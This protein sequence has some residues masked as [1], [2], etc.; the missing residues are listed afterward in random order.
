MKRYR[1]LFE[2]VERELKVT[3]EEEVAF[4]WKYDI[5]RVDY[6]A[7]GRSK[8]HTIN[9]MAKKVTSL[10]GCPREVHNF[11]C[12]YNQL[13]TLIGAPELCT[14]YF[15]CDRNRLKD[16]VGGPVEVRDSYSCEDNQLESLKGVALKIGGRFYCGGNPN[17]K[18]FYGL[19]EVGSI[20]RGSDI[21]NNLSPIDPREL[22]LYKNHRDVFDKWL[23]SD[24]EF[25]AYIQT[26]E[27]QEAIIDHSL[28]KDIENLWE[29]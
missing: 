22:D 12:D 16:L 29:N 13:E 17:L 5:G 24:L 15:S 11:G 23:L 2:S 26:R 4:R 20:S 21:S 10:I 1:D 25:E 19:K 7:N 14:M 27:Y 18:T 8:A 3:K 28:D 6:D 9:L